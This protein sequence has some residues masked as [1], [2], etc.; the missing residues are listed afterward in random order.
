MKEKPVV[1]DLFCGAGGE[2]QGIHWAMGD[3]IKLFA[4]NHWAV[5]CETHAKNFPSDECI[6]QD[7]T[8]VI[9]TNVV[10]N[11]KV[12]LM[13]A[14]PEC[15]PAGTLVL[16]DKGYLPIETIKEGDTVLTHKGRWR[17]VTP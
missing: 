2:S 14:S 1:I 5:A 9:P 12:A 6:C 10:P 3:N 13:W 11:R 17:K 7:I 8:T 16:T 15:F 4:V